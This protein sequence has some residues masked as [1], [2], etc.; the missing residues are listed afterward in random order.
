LR[1]WLA[2]K[3]CRQWAL[4]AVAAALAVPLGGHLYGIWLGDN[5][6][7][8][9]P[10]RVYRSSQLD[11]AD[12]A[13]VVRDKGIR[14][15]I[16][17]RGEC[18][19]FAWYVDQCKAAAALGVNHVDVNFSYWALPSTVELRRL[20]AILE[21]G[22]G[23]F[24]MHCRRGADRTGLGAAI[25]I[26]LCGD[27]G[28]EAARAQLSVRYGYLPVS[29]RLELRRFLDLY[30]AWLGERGLIHER[31]HFRAWAMQ[32]YQPDHL[33]ARIEALATPTALPYGEATQ[34]RFRVT[35]VSRL[36]WEFRKSAR[37]GVHLRYR[38]EHSA[39]E[40]FVFTGG[41]G[42]FDRT[43]PA[44]ASLE[45]TLTLPAVRVPGVYRLIVDMVDERM[46]PFE[47]YGS[48]PFKLELEVVADSARTL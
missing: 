4:L 13:R 47:V 18:A 42:F 36:P 22:E 31:A 43:L 37:A 27:G 24:L 14:T 40:E 48:T 38:L 33:C 20:I 25:A 8:V 19:K 46:G 26:L 39:D 35:N 34:A 2:S 16:N 17:L 41:A 30:E 21:T 11:E 44:G 9:V 10:G 3:R 28:L 15:V 1:N 12:L 23:P 45:L 29:G 32:H 7:E 5:L 6:H